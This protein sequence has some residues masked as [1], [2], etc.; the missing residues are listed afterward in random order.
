M[1]NLLDTIPMMRSADFKGRFKAEYWQ[2]KIRTE[3][4]GEMCEK[5]AAGELDFKPNCSLDLL[6]K[7]LGYMKNYLSCLEL[8]A[9]IEDI[10]IFD[11]PEVGG[12][13]DA[14]AENDGEKEHSTPQCTPQCDLCC[15][16]CGKVHEI[17]ADDKAAE[18][19]YA[20]ENAGEGDTEGEECAPPK[21]SKG[22]VDMHFVEDENGV[23]K[24]E[25]KGYA[26]LCMQVLEDNFARCAEKALGDAPI[27]IRSIFIDAAKFNIE[28]K[29]RKA[30]DVKNE[31]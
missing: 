29:L 9:E 27:L 18:P 31:C 28:K 1:K 6:Q 20:E 3:K 7:Q 24:S 10:Y 8:R 4:L 11:L 23:L 30:L 17:F 26:V 2:L 22:R 19:D 14:A 25:V 5:Y 21:D 12:C 13:E 16:V 15:R